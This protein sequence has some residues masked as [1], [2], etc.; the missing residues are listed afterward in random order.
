V[1]T[2]SQ[3]PVP[4]TFVP[5]AIDELPGV[6][7]TSGHCHLGDSI[8]IILAPC[9][10]VE[11][12]NDAETVDKLS[13]FSFR[14]AKEHGGRKR[15]YTVWPILG[16]GR[17][18]E[19]RPRKLL[20][21]R[22]VYLSPLEPVREGRF[23]GP[24]TGFETVMKEASLRD[25]HRHVNRYTFASRLAM[26]EVGPQSIGDLLGHSSHTMTLRYAHLCPPFNAASVERL[27][28]TAEQRDAKTDAAT[29]DTLRAMLQKYSKRME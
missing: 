9:L 14:E 13:A 12:S 27:C 11:Q 21:N 28:E 10:Q 3:L 25:Y 7:S 24:G 5:R 23:A 15:A 20:G 1:K 2:I 22:T 16:R 19:P 6:V 17:R 4:P 26:A 8:D 18:S 29:F